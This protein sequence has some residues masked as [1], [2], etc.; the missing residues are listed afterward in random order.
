MLWIHTPLTIEAIKILDHSAAI[1]GKEITTTV[2]KDTG[3]SVGNIT[4]FMNRVIKIDTNVK[5]S[6][7]GQYIYEKTS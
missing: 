4:Q 3:I 6:Y 2:E 5:K 7:R 1:S